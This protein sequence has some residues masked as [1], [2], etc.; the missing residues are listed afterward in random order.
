MKN[1]IVKTE[2]LKKYY[3][4]GENT[5]KAL[6]GVDFTVKEREFVGDYREI[7]KREEHPPSYD[8]RA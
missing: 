7:R 5:V 8:R 6:D 2:G 1:Q 3:R 4:L